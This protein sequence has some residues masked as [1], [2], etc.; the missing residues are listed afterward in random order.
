[1]EKGEVEGS[2][3]AVVEGEES[4]VMGEEIE[5]SREAE[6]AA[7]AQSLRGSAGG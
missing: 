7:C 4:E 5:G 6:D 2:R 1:M 3:A